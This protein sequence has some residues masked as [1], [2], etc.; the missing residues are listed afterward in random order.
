M[1][2]LAD[3]LLPL[4]REAADRNGP[5]TLFGLFEREESPGQWDLVVAA[6]WLENEEKRREFIAAVAS[7]L[8]PAELR[9]LSA[10]VTLLPEDEFVRS[11]AGVAYRNGL[12]QVDGLLKVDGE[13][14]VAD[15][16]VEM[17][18]FTL[19]GVP[20][21]RVMLYAANPLSRETRRE[22]AAAR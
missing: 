21:R 13:A 10:V 14:V 18:D 20:F 11:L 19:N 22:P 12:L 17:R 6:P 16:W 3:K 2:R 9:L 1:R 7:R 8:D 15:D 5:F 4:E